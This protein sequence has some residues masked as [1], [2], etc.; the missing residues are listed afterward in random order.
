MSASAA[1]KLEPA[2]AEP[3][4][5]NA[6]VPAW[7]PKT[8]D[9]AEAFYLAGI[10]DALARGGEAEADK[11]MAAAGRA[12]LWFLLRYILSSGTSEAALKL[13]RLNHPW[14]FDRC[15]EHLPTSQQ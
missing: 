1:Q 5:D 4:S 14:I 2:E 3:T 13:S 12:D 11:F 8:I 6:R 10:A 15:R 7:L 9:E